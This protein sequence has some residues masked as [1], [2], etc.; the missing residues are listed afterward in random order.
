M[1][2]MVTTGVQL[3]MTDNYK[4]EKSQLHIS[5]VVFISGAWCY[6]VHTLNYVIGYKQLRAS[7]SSRKKAE[8]GEK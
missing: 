5:S 2:V 8:K 1:V 3:V 6:L 7:Y 4:P